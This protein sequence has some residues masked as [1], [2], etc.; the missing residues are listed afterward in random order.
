VEVSRPGGTDAALGDRPIAGSFV[1]R[2][3]AR[4]AERSGADAFR[5]RFDKVALRFGAQLEEALH[6]IVPAGMTAL[7]AITAPLRQA[8]KTASE[9]SDAIR[10]RLKGRARKMD[11]EENL[12]G[13]DIIVRVAKGRAGSQRTI[14]L[15]HN[16][17]PNAR[18]L[19]DAAQSLLI[20]D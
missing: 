8:T 3:Q 11:M 13:N 19:L 15:V 14:V 1:D 10:R 12:Y 17:H 16:P 4:L 6:D 20:V 9:L 2:L 18:A 7:V 5:L